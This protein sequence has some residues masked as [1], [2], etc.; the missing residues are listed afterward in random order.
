MSSQEK[1][2]V[3]GKWLLEKRG[4]AKSD[5]WQKEKERDWKKAGGERM[6]KDT[7]ATDSSWKQKQSKKEKSNR[8]QERREE[9]VL[10][11]PLINDSSLGQV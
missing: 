8:D 9:K 7:R 10:F 4:N 3:D 1:K 5:I 6:K 11:C 2:G